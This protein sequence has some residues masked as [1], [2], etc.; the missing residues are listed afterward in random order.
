MKRCGL[1][2]NMLCALSFAPPQSRPNAEKRPMTTRLAAKQRPRRHHC[3]PSTALML[4]TGAWT[5]GTRKLL[6]R[7]S[8]KV[9]M[10]VGQAK[11][12]GRRGS[13]MRGISSAYPPS[14]ERKPNCFPRCFFTHVVVY[15][16]SRGVHPLK[17]ARYSE[18][19]LFSQEERDTHAHAGIIAGQSLLRCSAW[20]CS[21]VHTRA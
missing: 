21:Y 10:C 5:V 7:A 20:C 16:C 8:Q 2:E 12:W 9:R 1:D 13:S 17:L 14:C 3:A 4:H 15:C 18:C 19:E 6:L 11:K